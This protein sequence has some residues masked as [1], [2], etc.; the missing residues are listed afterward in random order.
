MRHLILP[1]LFA[2]AFAFAPASAHAQYGG[3]FGNRGFA[4][5]QRNF[6]FQGHGFQQRG[7]VRQRNFGVV[8]HQRFGAVNRGFV[9]QRSSV[10][11]R[12]RGILGRIFRR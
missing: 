8:G 4:G 3:G 9:Q 7:F 6:G 1:T 10:I 2:L 5:A 11:R 12:P